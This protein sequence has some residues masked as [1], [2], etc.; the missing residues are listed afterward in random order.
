MGGSSGAASVPPQR[1]GRGGGA[2]ADQAERGRCRR[3]AV[4][5]AAAHGRVK[6]SGVDAAAVDEAAAHGQIKQSGVDAAAVGDGAVVAPGEL[7]W[8][9]GAAEAWQ[10]CSR[11]VGRRGSSEAA[12]QSIATS[13]PQPRAAQEQRS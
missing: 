7:R 5:A 10:W 12:A 13:R 6:R 2:W 3:S 1:R 4:G 9:E 8:R 11:V